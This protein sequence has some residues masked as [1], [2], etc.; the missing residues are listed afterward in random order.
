M[1]DAQPAH[2]R[3]AVTKAPINWNHLNADDRAK[4]EKMMAP[5]RA[6][7]CRLDANTAWIEPNPGLCV[8][9]DTNPFQSGLA[10]FVSWKICGFQTRNSRLQNT[11]GIMDPSLRSVPPRVS[12]MIC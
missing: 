4:L 5:Y 11:D 3:K 9:H 2:Q 1:I 7:E 6:I 12:K 10:R 8:T